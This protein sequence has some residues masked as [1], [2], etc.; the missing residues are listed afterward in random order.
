MTSP[1]LFLTVNGISRLVSGALTPLLALLV[2]QAFA[3]DTLAT[4][5]IA[6]AAVRLCLTPLLGP[7]IDRVNAFSLLWR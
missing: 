5:V 3:I 2:T 4:C 7:L 1:Y 6:A